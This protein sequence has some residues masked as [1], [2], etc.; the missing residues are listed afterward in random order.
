MQNGGSTSRPDNQAG[1][2]GPA[3]R[4]T[5]HPAGDLPAGEALTFTCDGQTLTAQAGDTVATALWLAGVRRLRTMPE[6]DAPRGLFC[7]VGRCTDCLMTID[8]ELSVRSC[9]TPV[10]AGMVVETQ[11]GLGTWKAADVVAE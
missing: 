2:A 7:G 9:I 11:I 6:A 8:D 5:Q 4:I 3:R 10:R 1:I